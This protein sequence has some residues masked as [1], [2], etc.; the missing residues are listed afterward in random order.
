AS[1]SSIRPRLWLSSVGLSKSAMAKPYRSAGKT[2]ESAGPYPRALRAQT[3]ATKARRSHQLHGPQSRIRHDIEFDPVALLDCED[4]GLVGAPGEADEQ[5]VAGADDCHPGEED[6]EQAGDEGAGADRPEAPERDPG[7]G[8]GRQAR[9]GLGLGE[10]VAKAVG[11]ALWP[12]QVE[13]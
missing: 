2:R 12:P 10:G 1:G 8:L 13:P 11:G 4:G 3:V 6:A 5:G 9:R 7:R